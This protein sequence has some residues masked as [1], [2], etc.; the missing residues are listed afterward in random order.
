MN[1]PQTER[2]GDYEY[3][4][5]RRNPIDPTAWQVTIDGLCT[6]EGTATLMVKPNLDP[7]SIGLWEGWLNIPGVDCLMEGNRWISRKA[8]MDALVRSTGRTGICHTWEYGKLPWKWEGRYLVSQGTRLIYKVFNH[9]DGTV[10]GAV[11]LY[12]TGNGECVTSLKANAL[13]AVEVCE[14]DYRQWIKAVG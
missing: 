2:I 1:K 9:L 7:E 13:E 3:W 8:A 12:P 4:L 10:W 14:S 6:P 5:W 11:R